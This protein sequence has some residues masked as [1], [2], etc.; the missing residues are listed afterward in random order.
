MSDFLTVGDVKF[1]KNTDVSDK[2]PKGVK[3]VL[4]NKSDVEFIL[5]SVLENK[6]VLLE[7]K[8]GCGKTTLIKWLCQETNNVYSRVQ[9]DG[10]TEVSTFIGRYLIKDGSTYWVDGVLTEALKNGYWLLLD[11]VNAA[12]PDVLFLFHK[13]LDD[14]KMLTLYD[15]DNSVIH[16][17]PNFRLF[18]A[19]NPSGDYVGTKEMSKAFIDR[20]SVVVKMPYADP[21]VEKRILLEKT[22]LT[23]KDIED[24][25]GKRSSI[26]ERMVEFASNVRKMA[27]SGELSFHLSTR[28]LVDWGN[29]IPTF[30][31]LRAAQ[32]VI[33]NKADKDDADKI[34]DMLKNV[35]FR[36]SD[37][38]F[39]K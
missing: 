22:K 35:Y 9:V 11:E 12:L 33:L 31:V 16:P 30:G 34:E 13:L 3:Y 38:N 8:T 23:D 26:P 20:F 4:S 36:I 24:S 32:Y 19:V 5:Q 21:R 7:G 25:E 6:P 27:D 17:H 14:D 15:K 29:F 28:Q 1:P 18:A 37:D 39:R 10:G 2:V